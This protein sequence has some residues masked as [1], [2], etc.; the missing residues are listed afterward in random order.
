[1]KFIRGRTTKKKNHLFLSLCTSDFVCMLRMVQRQNNSCYSAIYI[2]E[3]LLQLAVC[4]RHAFERVCLW[5][6]GC[7]V[8]VCVCVRERE[9]ER[10]SMR[11]IF[12]I[13][14]IV[15]PSSAYSV[16]S[17]RPRGNTVSPKQERPKLWS[18]HR[19][20]QRCSKTW[21]QLSNVRLTCAGNQ[22]QRRRDEAQFPLEQQ[23]HLGDFVVVSPPGKLLAQG[24]SDKSVSM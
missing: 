9:R 2:P 23:Q 1:M 16:Y 17:V 12:N 21:N 14:H 19:A 8:Y 13:D 5:R 6:G 15:L 18:T 3:W 11:N 4:V 20:K 22:H 7:G 24:R 10:E